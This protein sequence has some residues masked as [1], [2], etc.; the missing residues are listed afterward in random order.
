[1]PSLDEAISGPPGGVAHVIAARVRS[2][3]LP[4]GTLIEVRLPE[5]TP[6]PLLGVLSAH[7]RQTMAEVGRA[8]VAVVVI[9]ENAPLRVW[10]GCNGKII[11]SE[12]GETF[13]GL[14]AAIAKL[15]DTTPP[16]LVAEFVELA[17][18][19]ERVR[20]MVLVGMSADIAFD[21]SGCP[22]AMNREAYDAAAELDLFLTMDSDSRL[23]EGSSLAWLPNGTEDDPTPRW[24]AAIATVHRDDPSPKAAVK[25]VIAALREAWV[26]YVKDKPSDVV[27][28]AL[29]LADTFTFLDA[30][31]EAALAAAAVKAAPTEEA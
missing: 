31:A 19:L 23:A 20:G 12:A 25:A 24:R 26:A 15:P 30:Q 21:L 1:M 9:S 13:L 16:A 7:L 22:E 11:N 28:L 29:G 10:P 6:P 4:P 8:D 27:T 2:H 14:E 5:T 18:R 3:A 17:K